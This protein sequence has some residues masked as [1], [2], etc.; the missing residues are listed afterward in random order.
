M[1]LLLCHSSVD[2]IYLGLCLGSVL[3]HWPLCVFFHQPRSLDNWSFLVSPEA[4]PCQ[5]SDFV[6]L[7]PYCVEGVYSVSLGITSA[8]TLLPY[9]GEDTGIT[10]LF[11]FIFFIWSH[12]KSLKKS[13]VL[14]CS[15]NG[16]QR[17]VLKEINPEYSLKGPMQK[18]KPQ[19]LGHLMGRANSL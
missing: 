17:S 11:P 2:C 15:V 13:N 1:P 12:G 6:L 4:R 3:F 19:Y 14:L 5:L 10:C 18:V 16:Y 8:V 7:F 9:F